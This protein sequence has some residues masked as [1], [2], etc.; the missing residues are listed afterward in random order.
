M[1]L[2]KGLSV[3]ATLLIL[4]GMFGCGGSDESNSSF[5]GI[6]Q[7]Y[8]LASGNRKL[9]LQGKTGSYTAAT[10]AGVN[11]MAVSLKEHTISIGGQSLPYLADHNLFQGG[12]F[13]G[14]ADDAV[15]DDPAKVAGTFNT[16]TGANF[17]GQLTI[18]SDDKFAWCQRG[19]FNGSGGC[20]DGSVP[21]AGPIVLLPKVGFKFSG[22][23]GNYAVYQQGAAG[24]IFPVDNRGLNLKALSQATTVPRG[25]FSQCLISAGANHVAKLSFSDGSKLTIEGVRNFSGTYSYSYVNG[26]IGFSSSACRNGTCTGIYND[27]LS[28]VYLAQVGNA[29]FF[30]R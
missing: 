27:E 6:N 17:L 1:R 16:L 9:Q 25:T 14:Y 13:V 30:K 8:V 20:T 19:N 7:T 29:I 2:I 23:A 15:I 3:I 5:N 28:L 4:G 18:G 26:A 11:T 12:G 21:I 22:I 10:F 24:A